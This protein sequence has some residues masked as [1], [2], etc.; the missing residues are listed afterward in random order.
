MRRQL[1][2]RRASRKELRLRF[3]S[4]LC[5]RK[6]ES[7][8]YF[9]TYTGLRAGNNLLTIKAPTGSPESTVMES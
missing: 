7:G 9:I 3:E 6:G 8:S 5:P 1:P 4:W 2:L